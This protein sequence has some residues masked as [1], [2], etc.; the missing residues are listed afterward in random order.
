MS[1]E[2]IAFPI[3]MSYGDAKFY[4]E[5]RCSLSL[6][7]HKG[8]WPVL[9]VN[10]YTFLQV[11]GKTGSTSAGRSMKILPPS[12]TPAYNS[13]LIEKVVGLETKI[14]V[15]VMLRILMSPGVLLSTKIPSVSSAILQVA[16]L[17]CA[18]VSWKTSSKLEDEP[19]YWGLANPVR[20]KSM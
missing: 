14:F 16:Q 15:E 13:K 11:T 12:G 19:I 2:I 3:S 7:V 9:K 17:A 20:F 18:L 8:V 4:V 5:I 1:T 10:P 6:Y